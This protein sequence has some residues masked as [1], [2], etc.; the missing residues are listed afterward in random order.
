MRVM[1]TM[2]RIGNLDKSLDFYQNVLGMKLIRRHDYPEHEFTLA[3][4]GYGDE[5]DTAVLELTHNWGTESYDLGNAYGHIAIGVEDVYKAETDQKFL[6]THPLYEFGEVKNRVAFYGAPKLSEFYYEQSL[7][8]VRKKRLQWFHEAQSFDKHLA[9]QSG[10]RVFGYFL[11][12]LA[13]TAFFIVNKPY[14][15]IN[16]PNGAIKPKTLKYILG[17][18]V[19]FGLIYSFGVTKE[20]ESVGIFLHTDASQKVIFSSLL[21]FFGLLLFFPAFY[22]AVEWFKET[23]IY[24]TTFIYGK[25]GSARWGSIK[26]YMKYIL[27]G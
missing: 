21:V 25:G 7:E 4:V 11:F 13:V 24:R 8:D 2:L 22:G 23:D 14:G 17:A 3:F 1:H 15:F 10:F 5:S 20:M 9:E 16:L 18:S 27:F 6:K 12:F 19:F 26:T